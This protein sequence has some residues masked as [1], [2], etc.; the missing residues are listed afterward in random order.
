MTFRL[1][2]FKPGDIIRDHD[3]WRG[4]VYSV[5]RKYVLIEVNYGT[6]Y[7]DMLPE[8]IKE[9]VEVADGKRK[10]GVHQADQA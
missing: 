7:L 6:G 4:K 2:D 1:G 3:N 8:D 5:G 10:I 9:I